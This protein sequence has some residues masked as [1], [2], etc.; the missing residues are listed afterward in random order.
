MT[1]IDQLIKIRSSFFSPLFTR[2]QAEGTPYSFRSEIKT[3][4]FGNLS[5]TF[6]YDGEKLLAKWADREGRKRAQTIPVVWRESNLRTGSRV[7]YFLL[8]CYQCRTLYSD[9]TGLYSRHQFK[10]FYYRQHLSRKSRELFRTGNGDPH[11]K[12]GKEYYRGKI[13]PYG[14]RLQRYE[15]NR[16]REDSACY[17]ALAKLFGQ[18]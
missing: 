6:A 7:P 3:P 14:R 15:E 13:T 12:N 8:G 11:R 1:N 10:H 18:T 2:V 5:F 16:K 9:G 4:Y 17:T